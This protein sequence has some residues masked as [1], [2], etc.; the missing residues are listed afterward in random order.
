MNSGEHPEK[1]GQDIFWSLLFSYEERSRRLCGFNAFTATGKWPVHLGKRCFRYHVIVHSTSTPV[2]VLISKSSRISFSSQDDNFICVFCM[3]DFSS[4]DAVCVINLLAVIFLTFSCCLLVHL[5]HILFWGLE[6]TF[7]LKDSVRCLLRYSP[8]GKCNKN[9][10]I[11]EQVWKQ[12][13]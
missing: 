12:L 10:Q 9:V 3:Y 1:L 2:S 5:L 13:P 6:G 4:G 8:T 7:F 11:S